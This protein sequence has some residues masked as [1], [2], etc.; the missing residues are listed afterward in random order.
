MTFV[1]ALAADRSSRWV[2]PAG[3]T[4]LQR[5]NPRKTTGVIESLAAYFSCLAAVV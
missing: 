2:I 4:A 5:V 1:W 3:A